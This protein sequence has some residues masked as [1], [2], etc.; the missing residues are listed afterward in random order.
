MARPGHYVCRSTKNPPPLGKCMM[1][2]TTRVRYGVIVLKCHHEA[3]SAMADA[4]PYSVHLPAEHK[5]LDFT[6]QAHCPSDHPVL[7]RSETRHKKKSSR[8]PRPLSVRLRR[9]KSPPFLP[10]PHP[11]SITHHPRLLLPPLPGG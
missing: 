2:P 8:K 9:S 1:S 3:T 4:Q 11:P 10:P 5:Q 6:W 7:R